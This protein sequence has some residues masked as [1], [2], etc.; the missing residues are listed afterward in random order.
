MSLLIDA[1]KKAE[2]AKHKSEAKSGRPALPG[3]AGATAAQPPGTAVAANASA[4]RNLFEVKSSRR[5]VSFPLVVGLLTT[6]ASIAIGFY[7]W[8]QLSPHG[9]RLAE[10]PSV[11]ERRPPPPAEPPPNSVAALAGTIDR[12][13]PAAGT[14]KSTPPSPSIRRGS[15]IAAPSR[16]S[17]QPEPP[18]ANRIERTARPGTPSPV[19]RKGRPAVLPAAL[20]E[21]WQHYQA[22]RL[23]EAARLYQ[24]VLEGDPH[25]VDALN[26]LGSIAAR[27]GHPAAA[28]RFFER[29]LTAR[30]EDPIATAGLSALPLDG[31][32]PDPAVRVSSLRRAIAQRPREGALH[33]AL[34]NAYASERRW[35]EAQLS[36]F[37]AYGLDRS[38]PDYLF[39]L[40]VSLDQLGKHDLARRF[41]QDALDSAGHRPHA[42]DPSGVRARLTALAGVADGQSLRGR[43]Q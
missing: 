27:S 22:N 42:F 32:Q 24:R 12:A 20:A 25:N 37:R 41:Y 6:I 21:A 28:A 1:L 34:G 39:N 35:A 33:F 7:F 36:Y 43:R 5:P 17:F 29:S 2:E 16:G 19:V 38:H 3:G 9:P 8:Q 4:A 14:G 10:P 11:A 30:P 18:R 31:R 23:P 13:P 26:G 40:G 15:R